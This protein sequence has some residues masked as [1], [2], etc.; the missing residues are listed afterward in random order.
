MKEKEI[1]EILFGSDGGFMNDSVGAVKLS[2]N[3]YELVGTPQSSTNLPYGTVVEAAP[4]R[5]GKLIFKKIVRLSQY[6]TYRFLLSSRDQQDAT[7]L[8]TLKEKISS[9]GGDCEQVMGGI[10]VIHLPKSA[11]FDLGVELKNLKLSP[12]PITDE[13]R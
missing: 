4:D 1:V 12:M 3:R 7:K 11:P 10:L 9:S 6:N 2:M 13:A 5:K 8:D